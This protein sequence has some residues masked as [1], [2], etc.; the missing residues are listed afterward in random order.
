MYLLHQKLIVVRQNILT[1]VKQNILRVC[2]VD[3]EGD[4]IIRLSLIAQIQVGDNLSP[5]WNEGG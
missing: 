3:W 5:Y 4:G 2:A 1:T